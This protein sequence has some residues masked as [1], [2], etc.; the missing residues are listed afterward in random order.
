MVAN[1]NEKKKNHLTRQFINI[2]LF[3]WFRKNIQIQNELVSLSETENLFVY[4]KTDQ[5]EK[6]YV[7]FEICWKLYWG[8]RKTNN[9]RRISQPRRKCVELFLQL[10]KEERFFRNKGS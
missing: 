3:N 2:Y 8:I 9:P 4:I 6:L 7:A 5:S 10:Q 1:K